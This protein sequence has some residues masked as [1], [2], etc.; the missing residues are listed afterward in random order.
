MPRPHTKAPTINVFLLHNE[1]TIRFGKEV[2]PGYC[3]FKNAMAR[4]HALHLTVATSETHSS[5]DAPWPVRKVKQRVL[6]CASNLQNNGFLVLHRG[7][8][9]QKPCNGARMRVC[10]LSW[11][12]WS[13]S[14]PHRQIRYGCKSSGRDMAQ[15]PCASKSACR[16]WLS[17]QVSIMLE[18]WPFLRPCL[19]F[20]GS[21][22]FH[23][24]P[25]QPYCTIR[26]VVCSMYVLVCSM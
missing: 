10:W 13:L 19:V 17:N 25:V 18:Q 4:A 2:S 7:N 21:A 9:Y 6:Q 8:G 22:L 24:L 12:T 20:P 1:C 5:G 3:G 11:S 23:L 16:T 14:E 15:G 26:N